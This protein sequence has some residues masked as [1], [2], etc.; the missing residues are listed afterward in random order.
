MYKILSLLWSM[1][2]DRKNK[3]RV[4]KAKVGR[5][6]YLLAFVFYPVMIVAS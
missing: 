6:F 5:K 2:F 1:Y 4:T 3:G